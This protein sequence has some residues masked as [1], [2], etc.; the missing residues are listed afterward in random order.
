MASNP[1]IGDDTALEWPTIVLVVGLYAAWL[2][3]TW[4]H[5]SIP[6][7]L[8]LPLAAWVSA[9]WGSAQHEM[10]HGHPSRNT[11]LN[12]ALATPPFWLYLP[13]ERYR[14]T[15]LA[16]HHDEILT[17][18]LDDPESRYW[19]ASDWQ[20]L[21]PVRRALV[22][23]QGTLA[24][25][26]TIGPLWVLVTFLWDEARAIASGDRERARVWAWHALW[27][28]LV[29]VWVVAICGVPLWQ[30]LLAFAYGGTALTLIRSFAE[31]RAHEDPARR[32]AVVENSRV[33]GRLFLY[34]N[35]HAAHH[36]WPGVS[37]HRLPRVYRENRAALL[38]DNGGLVYDGYRDLFARY[39]LRR[40]DAEVHP[41]R[42]TA[43]K[44]S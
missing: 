44:L 6:V 28:A 39:F 16:H 2:V 15:H 34:N 33:F 3:L 21:G 27:V 4:Y 26:I 43:D 22:R 12:T 25:R 35:L 19:T 10:L 29:L 1:G 41:I 23:A 40:H 31:H 14:Q 17:D 9:W 20:A 18:P 32:T 42:A 7:W 38:A 8:W 11:A 24:G 37:W 36:R 13:F 30:Y 5:A